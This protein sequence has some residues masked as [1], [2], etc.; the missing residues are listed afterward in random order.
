MKIE[1]WNRKLKW[2]ISV[3]VI[4]ILLACSLM[5]ILTII[6]LRSLIEYTDDSYGYYK[7]YYM[8]KA[9][10]ELALTEIDNTDVWFQNSINSWD[11][12]VINNFGC[13]WCNFISEIKWRSNLIS[14]NFWETT[15]CEDGQKL[16]IPAKW[17]MI[18]P[19][20]YDNTTNF[21]ELLPWNYSHCLSWNDCYILFSNRMDLSINWDSSKN[22]NIWVVF[23]SWEDISLEYL[24]MDN[25]TINNIFHSYFSAF[26]SYYRDEISTITNL[27]PY[28]VLSNPNGEEVK[29][30]INS[31]VE[32]PT[33]K[34]FVYSIWEYMWKTVWLQA[35]YEQ[36]VPSFLIN[37]YIASENSINTSS[38]YEYAR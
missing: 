28:I 24:Y 16:S 12:I 19:M 29:F 3:M 25:Y 37:P 10:L 13:P 23:L 22:L 38:T 26:Q 6:F 32:R 11:A 35:I 1:K 34:Y 4:L 17:S 15:G 9:W 27:L 8:A 2:N 20:F 36:P 31:K 21:S 14:N 7:S 18:L 30:C 33:T 5:G